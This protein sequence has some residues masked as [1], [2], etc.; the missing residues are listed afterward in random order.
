MAGMNIQVHPVAASLPEDFCVIQRRPEDPLLSLP[1]DPSRP[2][3]FLPG[4]QLTQ[5]RFDAL[6]LNKSDFLWPEEVK[7]AAHVLKVNETALAWTEAERGC[8]CN[9]Y[10]S[11]VRIL[12]VAHRTWTQKHILIPAGLL[13]KVIDMFRDWSRYCN[14]LVLLHAR[15]PHWI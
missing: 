5:D 8:F 13:D 14:P 1:E 15:P 4:V 3:K 12:T 2:P 6:E 9:E 7:L 11:P 10:F